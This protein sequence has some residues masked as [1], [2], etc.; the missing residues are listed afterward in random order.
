MDS[1]LHCPEHEERSLCM[2]RLKKDIETYQRERKQMQID[3]KQV[4][5]AIGNKLTI[6][7]FSLIIGFLFAITLGIAGVQWNLMM[8]V[9]HQVHKVAVQQGQ[10]MGKLGIDKT[11]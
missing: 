4:W 8:E 7:M 9:S 6:K 1:K 10:L 5:T 2:V 11:P 3:L